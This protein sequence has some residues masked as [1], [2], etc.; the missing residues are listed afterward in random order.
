MILGERMC[1]E[2]GPPFGHH[3]QPPG[4]ERERRKPSISLIQEGGRTQKGYSMG[5]G[6]EKRTQLLNI[7]KGMKKSASAGKK[8]F[9]A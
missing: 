5:R 3:N 4:V 2:G 1:V 8:L 6:H 9:S 7:G